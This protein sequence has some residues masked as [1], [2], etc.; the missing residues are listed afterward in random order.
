M[1]DKSEND[2]K[3]QREVTQFLNSQISYLGGVKSLG[4]WKK[5]ALEGIPVYLFIAIEGLYTS[6]NAQVEADNTLVS[7]LSIISFSAI[8]LSIFRIHSQLRLH[9]LNEQMRIINL[10]QLEL[11]GTEGE[12]S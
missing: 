6:F 10:A 3:D 2:L 11:K 5:I 12:S 1:L 9:Q 8:G 4:F 7:L